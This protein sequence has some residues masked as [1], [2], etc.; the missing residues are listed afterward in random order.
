MSS[1]QVDQVR[2][3]LAKWA[4]AA[5]TDYSAQAVYVFG[6]LVYRDGTQFMSSSDADLVVLLPDGLDALRRWRWL[7]PFG[8]YV[9]ELEV[10]LMRALRRNGAEPAVSVV[11]VTSAELAYDVHKDGHREFFTSNVFRDLVTGKDSGGLPGAGTKSSDRFTAGALAFTQKLRNNYLSVSA[12]GTP[13][14]DRFDGPDPVPKRIM[15]AAAMAARAA[16]VTGGAGAEHDVKEGLDLLTN[17]LYR[18][19]EDDP[20]YRQLQDIVSVRRHGRGELRS[21]DAADQLLLAEMIY[22]IAVGSGSSSEGTDGVSDPMGKRE[23]EERLAESVVEP[24]ESS[25]EA[26]GAQQASETVKP[27][28]RMRSST[29]FFAH[30]FGD[31]FPGV[32]STTWFTDDHDIEQRMTTLL[33]DP[34]TFADGT[35]VWYWRGGNLHIE[36][37]RRTGPGTYLMDVDELRIARIAAVHGSTYKRHFVYVACD[38]MD[39]TGLYP[40]SMS[41]RDAALR[42]RG[43]DYEEYGLVGGITPITRSEYDD[44]SATIDGE[45]TAISGASELRVRYTSPYNFLIAA[46]GSPINNIEFDVILAEHMNQALENPQREEEVIDRVKKLVEKLPLRVG[47]E[48]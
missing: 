3:E 42:Q 8:E 11:A 10:R 43:Y 16:G 24:S 40:T 19:R 37:F 21:I 4:A 18:R 15:R 9:G 1:N 22:D 17:E 38:A 30:R 25:T 6:S 47:R 45:L 5:V 36:K 12:N 29:V 23:T 32:R 41:D 14:L 28:E 7:Q 48:D 13:R 31:A 26:L 2:E 20:A 27:T 39:P 46:N 44:G 34:L 33:R 35:P